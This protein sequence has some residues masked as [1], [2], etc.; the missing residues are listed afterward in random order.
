VT[1]DNKIIIII[2]IIIICRVL[3]IIYTVQREAFCD[4]VRPSVT[5]YQRLN[6]LSDF[7]DI[8]YGSSEQNVV[9]EG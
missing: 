7:H 3:A 6:R 4:H 8:R 1:R 2:I 5:E 9:D